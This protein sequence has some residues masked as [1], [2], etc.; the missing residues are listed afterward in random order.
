MMCLEYNI[1]DFVA[2]ARCGVLER[3]LVCVCV[4]FSLQLNCLLVKV[5]HLLCFTVSLTPQSDGGN[6]EYLWGRY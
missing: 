1:N 2:V 5:R 4:A 6:V 3:S